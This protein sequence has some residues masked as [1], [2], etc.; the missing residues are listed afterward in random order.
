VDR[1]RRNRHP[2]TGRPIQ[3]FA[4]S[5]PGE[6]ITVSQINER[7]LVSV[8]GNKAPD[9]ASIFTNN[10]PSFAEKGSLYPL[11]ELARQHGMSQ[12]DYLPVFWEMCTYRGTLYAL[13]TTG[14][15]LALHYNKDLFREAGLDPERPPRT[16]EELDRMSE[17]LTR[18]DAKG[19]M[20]RIGFLPTQPGWWHAMWP[21]W[22]GGNIW[23]GHDRLT[24]D[25]DEYVRAL[26]WAQGYARKYG[27][28]TLQNFRSGFGNFNSP[29]DPFLSGQIAMELQGVW[30][31]NFIDKYNPGLDCGVAPFPSAVRAWKTCPWWRPTFWLSP[32][33]PRIRRKRSNSSPSCKNGRTWNNC[34][35]NSG[36]CRPFATPASAIA[37]TSSSL[38]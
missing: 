30:M 22:F 18:F 11:D 2:E 17:Q 35:W 27:S 26:D 20:V 9:I 15:T 10:I 5:N 29:Q 25:S 34:V 31:F 21:I 13:P 33:M 19:R 36:N 32:P 7:F 8:A 3:R 37:G 12:E 38:F 24:I 14:A 23:D 16:L 6:K 28:D 1:I 4:R